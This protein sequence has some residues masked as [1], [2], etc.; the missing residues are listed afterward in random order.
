L[1]GASAIKITTARYV[2]PSGR[3]INKKGIQPN[4]VVPMDPHLVGIPSRD[5]QLRTALESVKKQLA[6]AH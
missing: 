4:V 5:V 2:T 1:P 6:L 3:D